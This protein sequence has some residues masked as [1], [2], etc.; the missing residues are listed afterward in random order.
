[1]A[2]YTAGECYRYTGAQTGRLSDAKTKISA[3]RQNMVLENTDRKTSLDEKLDA[4]VSGIQALEN[5]LEN[6][7]FG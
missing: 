5:A 1:M 4:I 6:C 3:S 7:S 2:R